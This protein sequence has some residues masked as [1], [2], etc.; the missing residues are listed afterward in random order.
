MFSIVGLQ[1]LRA[2]QPNP[3]SRVALPTL[4]S[5]GAVGQHSCQNLGLA[6]GY[7]GVLACV[8]PGL[9]SLSGCVE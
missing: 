4:S 3:I 6:G 5:I 8:L 7:T 1:L 9:A 2:G